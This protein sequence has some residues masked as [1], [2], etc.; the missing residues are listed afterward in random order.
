[1]GGF[2]TMDSA[3]AAL[4]AKLIEADTVI[5]CHYATFPMLEQSADA[6]K[7]G[8]EEATSSQVVVLEPGETHSV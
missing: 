4:A 8:V 7:A 3:D 1:M 2:Y 5:P 6:F